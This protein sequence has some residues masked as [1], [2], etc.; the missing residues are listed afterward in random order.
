MKR[1]IVRQSSAQINAMRR[2]GKS[3]TD[4]A[5]VKAMQDSEI[6]FSDSPELTPD[7]FA[8]AVVRKGLKPVTAKVQL[9]LRLDADVLNWFRAQ[10]RGYQTRINALLR[11]YRDAH[12]KV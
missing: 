2:A 7:A 12:R 8:R 1:K 6:D 3:R 9:T 10:G 5:R 4:W 11:A